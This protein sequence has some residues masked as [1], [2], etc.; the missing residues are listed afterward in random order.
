VRSSP[1]L[2]IVAVLTLQLV[3]SYSV[4]CGGF[5]SKDSR[6]APIGLLYMLIVIPLVE[7]VYERI[8]SSRSEMVAQVCAAL[9]FGLLLAESWAIYFGL[10]SVCAG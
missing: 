2:A 6:S 7:I 8:R 5:A 1:V 3:S 9:L 4:T 10:K